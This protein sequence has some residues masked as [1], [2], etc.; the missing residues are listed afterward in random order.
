MSAQSTLTSDEAFARYAAM[1]KRSIKGLFAI[2]KGEGI[3]IGRQT[4]TNWSRKDSWDARLDAGEKPASIAPKAAAIRQAAQQLVAVNLT[5]SEKV[6]ST[7][8]TLAALTSA[9]AK[10]SIARLQELQRNE[11]MPLD[12]V[13]SMARAAA[14]VSK[15]LATLA[16]VAAPPPAADA[17][18]DSVGVYPPGI[19]PRAPLVDL[20]TIFTPTEKR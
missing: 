11:E 1:P 5:D 15:A 13:L 8:A 2:L 10:T 4:L 16:Q 14:D 9:L 7:V 12:E 6:E 18:P 20:K 17:L 3:A 19:D